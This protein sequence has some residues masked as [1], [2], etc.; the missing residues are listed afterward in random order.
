[1]RADQVMRFFRLRGV[2]V[3]AAGCF[4]ACGDSRGVDDEYSAVQEQ[5]RSHDRE[6]AES[7][8]EDHAADLPQ[9]A[10]EVFARHLA[11]VG[12]REAFDT[13]Q[14][15]VLRFAVQSVRGT[16]G[17]LV[18][19]YRKP[20][21]YRQ[22]MMGSGR[23]AVT[24]GQRVWWITEEGWEV[25]ENE[26]GYI[27]LA[28]MDNHLVNPDALGIRHEYAGV[29]GVDG[30]PGFLVRRVWP[31]GAE[32]ELFFSANSGLLT[33]V[34]SQSPVTANSWF[35]YWDYR[36]VGGILIPFTHIRSVGEAGPPHGL[37][38]HSVEINSLLPDSLFLPPG[39]R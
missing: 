15:M 32:S 5:L 18:R 22:E 29:I 37:V 31:H 39:E 25:A 21:H 4:V 9:S 28:S 11:A 20:L 10:E 35:S 3:L 16:F 12:G 27:P 23:A 14:T 33:A 38:L 2:Q 19:Y 7:Y 13:I 36:D 8:A 1:M 6:A 30:T 17:E 26:T 24:D 34:R